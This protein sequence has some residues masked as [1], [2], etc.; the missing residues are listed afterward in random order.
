MRNRWAILGVVGAVIVGAAVAA[1]PLKLP[2]P[3]YLS[4][5]ARA[6]LHRK[7]VNH[8][9]STTQLVLAVTVLN[10]PEAARLANEVA[11]EPSIARPIDG[12]AEDLGTAFPARFFVLQDEL[13][14]RAEALNRAAVAGKPEA[15]ATAFG[16]VMETCVSCHAA[17]LKQP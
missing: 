15:M 17:Y 16:Q 10:Y 3:A 12:S 13:K 2:E 14:L 6:S 8:R 5:V 11:S 1:R 4:K 9:D 7:M